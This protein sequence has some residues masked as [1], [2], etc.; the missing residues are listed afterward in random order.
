MNLL[1]KAYKFLTF[2][3]MTEEIKKHDLGATFKVIYMYLVAL[4]SVIVFIIGSVNLIDTALKTWV[5]PTTGY[6]QDYSYNCNKEGLKNSGFKNNEECLAHFAKVE[7]KDAVNQRN[8]DLSFGVSMTAV[9][10]PI[11]LLH[12]A[13]I[14]KDKKKNV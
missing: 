7:Q 14:R 3:I 2:T 11:W 13:M 9:S 10:L 5:F 1:K 12:M 6:Y 4:I 8:K